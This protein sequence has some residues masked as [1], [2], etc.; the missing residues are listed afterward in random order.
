M[1]TREPDLPQLD[2]SR[3]TGCGDCVAICPTVCLEMLSST[4]WLPRPA[5]CVACGACS[6]ICEPAA[7]TWLTSL[8]SLSP[9]PQSL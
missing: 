6:T 2:A 3:C 9:N 8:S 1:T 4:V 5:D 7:L